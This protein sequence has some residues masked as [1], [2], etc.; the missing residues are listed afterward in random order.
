MPYVVEVEG[1]TKRL[2]VLAPQRT[3]GLLRAWGKFALEIWEGNR[4]S[5]GGREI[6]SEP[7]TENLLKRNSV[8]GRS[9]TIGTTVEKTEWF[10]E[11]GNP[12]GGERRGGAWKRSG[13]GTE[14]WLHNLV[15]PGHY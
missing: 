7:R 14:G 5:A 12:E 4:R 3:R 6:R 13:G 2:W 8:G 1:K 11:C 10:L 9:L 15:R